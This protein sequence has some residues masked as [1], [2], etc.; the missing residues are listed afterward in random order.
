MQYHSSQIGYSLIEVLI[1]IAVLLLSIVGPLT[2]AAKSLQTSFQARDQ[3]VA[4]YLAQEGIEGV[5]ALKQNS[6]IAGIQD[7]NLSALWDWANA[8]SLAD[9]R[10]ADGCNFDV[11]YP[12]SL[13][14]TNFTNTITSCSNRADCRLYYD[15]TA[16]VAKYS[17][18]NSGEATAFTRVITLENLDAATTTMAT[19]R[20][21]WDGTAFAGFDREVEISTVLYNVYGEL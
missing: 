6:V 2:I 1:A 16:P 5:I 4:T 7:G 21:T 9:C 19:V 3:I 11:Q 10:S 12:I 13:S 17:L 18:D 15:E 14:D 20:V 8:A